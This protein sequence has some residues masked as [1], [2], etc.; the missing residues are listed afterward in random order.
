[1]TYPSQLLAEVA[2]LGFRPGSAVSTA[3]SPSPRDTEEKR[4]HLRLKGAYGLAS[5]L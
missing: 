5:H 4:L 1:M 3:H 2:A